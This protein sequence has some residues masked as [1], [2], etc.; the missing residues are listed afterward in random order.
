MTMGWWNYRVIARGGEYAIYEVYYDDE[1]NIEAFTENSVCPMGESF[2]ELCK[3]L[4]HYQY[5]LKRPVLNYAK[6]SEQVSVPPFANAGKGRHSEQ[7]K[8]KHE[9]NEQ[10]PGSTA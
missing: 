7:T 3:D 8:T 6:L 9:T 4:E 10:N 1:G 5:A 2:D